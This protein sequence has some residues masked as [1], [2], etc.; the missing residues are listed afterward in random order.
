MNKIIKPFIL[1]AA[2]SWIFGIESFW[3]IFA[4]FV[5]GFFMIPEWDKNEDGF[6]K[7]IKEGNDLKKWY[8]YFPYR[9]P[10][11]Q[12]KQEMQKW[13]KHQQR[14]GGTND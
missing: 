2:M 7:D 1:T 4:I 13:I 9:A 10:H 6:Q 8:I 11:H 3:S 5:F 12:G 14:I